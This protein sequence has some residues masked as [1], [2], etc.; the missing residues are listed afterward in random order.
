MIA[1][2]LEETLAPA[3]RA[4][5]LSSAFVMYRRLLIDKSYV[6]AV[7][8]G[9]FAQAGFFAYLAGSPQV[10]ISLHGVSPAAYSLLFGLNAVALIGSAQLTAPLLRRLAPDPIVGVATVACLVLAIGLLAATLLR[11]DGLAATVV[12]LFL[13]TACLGT[14]GPITAMQAIENHPDAAGA[15]SALMGSIQFGAGALASIMLTQIADDSARPLSV[16]IGGC[17]TLAVVAHYLPWF[18]RRLTPGPR[19]KVGEQAI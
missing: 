11:F 4:A 18:R 15:A 6:R 2:L 3:N 1:L 8:T 9:A 17:A 7:L 12:L 16:I 10:F 14:I 13:M 19:L 5:D